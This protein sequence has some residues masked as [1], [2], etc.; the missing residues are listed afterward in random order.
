MTT[1]GSSANP[2]GEY[3]FPVL[4]GCD[5]WRCLLRG[6]CHAQPFITRHVRRLP[7]TKLAAIDPINAY[8]SSSRPPSGDCCG[9][10]LDTPPLVSSS[11]GALPYPSSTPQPWFSRVANSETRFVKTERSQRWEY[12]GQ[13]SI[14]HVITFPLYSNRKAFPEGKSLGGAP[15]VL[16]FT[17]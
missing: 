17:S 3:S 4:T 8:K 7:M 2:S 9:S 5:S 13:P 14:S 16:S 12:S 15:V 1:S 10:A 6:R 11:G